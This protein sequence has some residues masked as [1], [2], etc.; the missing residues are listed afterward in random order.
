MINIPVSLA[1]QI[2]CCWLETVNRQVE[3]ME[4]IYEKMIKEDEMLAAALQEE[5]HGYKNPDLRE[6][7]D[8]ELAMALYRQDQVNNFNKN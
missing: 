8:M 3:E 6:I 2:Y 4:N 5:E 7:M 1:H